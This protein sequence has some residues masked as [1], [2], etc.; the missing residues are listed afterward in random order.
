M[1]RSWCGAGWVSECLPV[2]AALA[3]KRIARI[4]TIGFMGR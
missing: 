3:A 1:R 2:D 4:L